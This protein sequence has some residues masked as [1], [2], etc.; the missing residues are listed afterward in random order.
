MERRTQKAEELRELAS[1]FV[2]ALGPRTSATV[3]AL[4]GELGAGKT[5]FVQAAA[6]ALGV[7]EA[8]TS[9][10][11]VIEKIYALPTQKGQTFL[12]FIHID[13]YRLKGSHEL[14]VLDWKELIAEPKNL[15][16]LE[17]PE[18]VADIMPA[19]AIHIRFEIDGDGRIITID[20][21]EENREERR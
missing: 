10:T 17:W 1:S 20:G 14:E 2:R 12:R 21:S 6:A 4:S 13:A 19:D 3:L 8:V 18:R 16:L 11:F 5:T 7:K 15:I 9:P